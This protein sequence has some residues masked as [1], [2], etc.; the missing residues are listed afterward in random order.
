[1]RYHVLTL[2]VFLG[3]VGCATSAPETTDLA[4]YWNV[5]T[6]V[7][8]QGSGKVHGSKSL[9]TDA[10]AAISRRSFVV[11]TE[12]SVNGQ[13]LAKPTLVVYEG[14]QGKIVIDG[15]LSFALTVNHQ[16][17]DS[18][19]VATDISLSGERIAPSLLVNLGEPASVTIDKTTLSLIVEE[20]GAND[21]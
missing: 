12:L 8:R 10:C 4:C 13:A 2:M 11:R 19:L 16:T 20:V 9:A 6:P 15:T 18:A 7:L 5:E 3:V 14:E 21:A 1:M 17:D